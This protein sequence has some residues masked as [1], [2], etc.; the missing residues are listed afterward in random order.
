[1]H[2]SDW[3]RNQNDETPNRLPYTVRLLSPARLV[4]GMSRLLVLLTLFLVAGPSLAEYTVETP[5]GDE[6]PVT[7]H[8]ADGA[9]RIVWLSS[10]FGNSPRRT[11]LATALSQ[12]GVEVWMPDLHAAWFLPVG[13]YSLNDVDPAA[14]AALITDAVH[15]DEKAVYL[16][17]EGRTVALA[18]NAVHDWQE[19]TDDTGKLRGLM[20]FSPRLFVRT[21]Q[22]GEAAEYL[23]IATASN[24]PIYI[25]QPEDSGGYWRIAQ[26]IAKLE[27]GGSPVFLHR[28][29]KVSDGYYARPDYTDAEAAAT[30]KL[31]A[32]L[33]QAM[34]MLD[35][36]GGTPATPVALGTEPHG[37]EQPSSS[38]LL[39]PFPDPKQAPELTLPTL[40]AG[41]MDLAQLR[42]QVV[43]VNF[44]AT[45]CPP[46]VEEIP[47]LQRLYR[48]L[49]GEGLEILAVDVGDSVAVMEDFL[50]DKPIEF[51]VLMDQDGEALR[52]WGVYAFPTTLVLDRQHRIRYAVFGAFD[53]SSQ[54]VIETLRPLLDDTSAAVA[55]DR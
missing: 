41:D 24:L 36:Y 20:A 38:E 28:L 6:I 1:M 16:M 18:L 49:H 19:H 22:G 10:E 27:Q 11:A 37:P 50:K 14:I 53:W 47:S 15:K 31:P 21:P 45:W 43:L 25:L 2:L 35:G 17:G 34:Q 3:R 52:R 29:P 5:D 7:I 39:R 30:E 51:P 33:V 44:W 12:R 48:Q 46:C 54:E 55:T 13:R 42:G 23:P 8:A 4:S 26:D 9:A 32:Q 40:R